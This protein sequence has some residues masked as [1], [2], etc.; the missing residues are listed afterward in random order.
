MTPTDPKAQPKLPPE[1]PRPFN[2]ERLQDAGRNETITANAVERAALAKRLGIVAVDS[3]SAQIVMSRVPNEPRVIDM[4]GTI[5]AVVVQSSVLT[6]EPITQTVHDEFDTLFASE[7][8]VE[9]WLRDNP[10]DEY[11]A[12][13][14][15][16]GTWLDMGEVATQYLSLALD[17]YPREADLP[18]LG[19]EEESAGGDDKPPSPFAILAK[20]KK[21]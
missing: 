20:L 3:F 12:P 5:D 17:P 19:E 21:D 18:Y 9:R 1:F 15:L 8:Y 16:D 14:P 10:Q 7:G 6:G 11:D 4:R 2:A 13:E